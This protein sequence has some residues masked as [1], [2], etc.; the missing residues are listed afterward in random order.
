MHYCTGWVAYDYCSGFNDVRFTMFRFLTLKSL[1][2]WCNKRIERW[3]RERVSR[4]PKD[5]D[6]C[7]GRI[8]S[9]KDMIRV[10]EIL[11]KQ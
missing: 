8:E 11:V 5:A 10:L 7:E 1:I 3:E 9:Y 4:R 2:W 6:Y